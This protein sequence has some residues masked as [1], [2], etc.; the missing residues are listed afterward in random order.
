MTIVIMII[1]V[2]K[3]EGKFGKEKNENRKNLRF[4]V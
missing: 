4:I 3:R 1:T 2:R